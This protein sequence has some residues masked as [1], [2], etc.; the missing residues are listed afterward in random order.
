MLYHE[1]NSSFCNTWHAWNINTNL[2][3]DI[4]WEVLK[5][6]IKGMMWCPIYPVNSK[7]LN[8]RGARLIRKPVTFG[9]MVSI[10]SASVPSPHF[11]II[12]LVRDVLRRYTYRVWISSHIRVRNGYIIR[13]SQRACE[14]FLVYYIS[15]SWQIHPF[16]N[17]Q[18]V[19]PQLRHLSMQTC[20]R[21]ESICAF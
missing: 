4:I 11:E 15:L 9:T 8:E 2:N 5:L 18:V 3:V 10:C 6:D 16:W 7:F 1:N 14:G 12:V 21:L 20:T 13:I 17:L 19:F